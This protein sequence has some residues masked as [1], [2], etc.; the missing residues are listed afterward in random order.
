MKKLLLLFLLS[1]SISI[2]AQ[3]ISPEVIAT[4]GDYYTSSS[5]S[6]SWTLGEMIVETF[7]SS[8]II[9]TQGFQQPYYSLVS[10]VENTNQ[11]LD[12]EFFPN[13]VID[14]FTIRINSEPDT[15]VIIEIIDIQGKLLFTT[16]THEKL[17]KIDLSN[18][19]GN[20]Y[21]LSIQNTEN[22]QYSIYKIIK[23]N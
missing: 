15:E 21:I 3:T 6:L 20:I 14:F 11:E 1:F 4:S 23:T 12:I 7:S 10:I 8:S 16:Q 17:T 5:V 18:Y 13:P 2:N 22:E 19:S 9:L